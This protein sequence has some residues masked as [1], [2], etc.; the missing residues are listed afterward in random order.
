MARV[1]LIALV[2][3]AVAAV[4]G[5]GHAVPKEPAPR[6]I[7]GAPTGRFAG[8]RPAAVIIVIHGGGWRGLDPNQ[9]R[10]SIAVARVLRS[11]GYETLSIDYRRG[12]Q[13]IDDAD[14]FYRRARARFGARM[15]VCAFGASAGGQVALMLAV[16]H[17]D[18]TCALS[19]AG[20]TDLTALAD[21]PGG[22]T[23]AQLA[24]D[25]FGR[26]GLARFSP[27]LLARR[28]RARLLLVAADDDPLVPLAQLRRMQRAAPSAQTIV[29]PGDDH[30][31]QFVH[32]RVRRAAAARAQAAEVRFLATVVKHARAG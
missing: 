31:A 11:L 5:C 7:W 14:A 6:G 3:A 20:P 15:P 9:L 22:A 25:A 10:L 13:G 26:D 19:L 12:P 16:R 1:R 4:A 24:L 27:A 2:L 8:H 23:A 30:G 17:P 29:L 21:E 18:L 28:I 32:S